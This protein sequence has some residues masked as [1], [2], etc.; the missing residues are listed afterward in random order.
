M[1]IFG[2]IEDTVVTKNQNIDMMVEK[3]HLIYKPLA[4]SCF[5]RYCPQTSSDSALSANINFLGYLYE[6]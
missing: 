4:I 2:Y 1:D 5:I 3:L 6:S